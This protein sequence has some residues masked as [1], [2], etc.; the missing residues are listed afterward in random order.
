MTHAKATIALVTLAAV[1]AA[2]TATT[3]AT[4]P[5]S[6]S[7]IINYNEPFYIF[8]KRSGAYCDLDDNPGL[9]SIYCDTG[10]TT[11]EGVTRF[12]IDA[13]TAS[14]PV[15]SS[16]TVDGALRMYPYLFFCAV[17]GTPPETRNDIICD[18]PLPQPFFQFVN[19]VWPM[20]DPWLHG[21]ST[22]VLFKH[23]YGAPN[24]WCTAPPPHNN[25]GRVECDR[26]LYDEWETFYFVVT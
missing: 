24:S 7:P 16:T 6:G 25:N 20:P 13:D 23:T 3:T 12:S 21:N 2:M 19:N 8:S 10:K 22:P 11:P 17:V 15:P 5:F 9:R 26:L 1:L 14:G 18:L 4:L